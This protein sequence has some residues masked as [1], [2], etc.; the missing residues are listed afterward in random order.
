M[1]HGRAQRWIGIGLLLLAVVGVAIALTAVLT[2]LPLPAA[3]GTCGPGRGSESAI[4]AFFD[5]G[6]IG[7]GREPAGNTVAHLQWYAF[8][9]QCQ[10]ATNSRML[11]GLAVLVLALLLGVAGF[12]FLRRSV[13]GAPAGGGPSSRASGPAPSGWGPRSGEPSSSARPPE[14]IAPP[15]GEPLTPPADRSPTEDPA[16]PVG[17]GVVGPRAD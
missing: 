16:P 6:S 14:A 8:V 17:S 11:I 2:A 7:A 10:A 13:V 12:L 1:V 3:G 9:G 15:A 4:G 5:P